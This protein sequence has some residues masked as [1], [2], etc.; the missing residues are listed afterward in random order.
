M[1]KVIKIYC[2]GSCLG[3]PGPWWYACILQ[4]G[5]NSKVFEW[6]SKNTTNNQMELQAVIIALESVKSDKYNIEIYLDS[7]YVYE[8]IT[9]YIENWINSWWKLSNKSPVKNVDLWQ[10]LY[11][12]TKWLKINWNWVK[13]HGNDVMNNLVDKI[14]RKQANFA[15]NSNDF[16]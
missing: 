16:I 2:D 14:A 15:K 13:W 10:K 9:K 4:F 1:D 6:N 8:W 12:L 5:E 11:E 3:N 7:K